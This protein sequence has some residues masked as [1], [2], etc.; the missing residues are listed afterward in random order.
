[1]RSNN[2]METSPVTLKRLV[3]IFE[4]MEYTVQLNNDGDSIAGA[5]DSVVF[6]FSLSDDSSWLQV[7]TSSPAP[8]PYNDLPKEEAVALLQ[9]AANAWNQE[10]YQPSAFPDLTARDWPCR[11]NDASRQFPEGVDGGEEWRY[12]FDFAAF[13]APGMTDDQLRET[14]DRCLAVHLQANKTIG[15]FT[16]PLF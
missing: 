5:W 10:Y 9:D 3:D 2:E 7:R 1:M 14:L 8:A 6:F 15:D 16:P 12:I 13:V 4:K 11:V